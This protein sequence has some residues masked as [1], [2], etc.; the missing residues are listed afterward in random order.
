MRKRR[1]T[2]IKEEK[3]EKGGKGGKRGKG[4]VW[5][6][7]LGDKRMRVSRQGAPEGAD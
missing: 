6:L 1:K 4:E 7:V 3:E 2:E 5:L